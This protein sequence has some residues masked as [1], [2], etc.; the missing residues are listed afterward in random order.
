MFLLWFHQEAK[1]LK[2]VSEMWSRTPRSKSLALNVEFYEQGR[3]IVFRFTNPPGFHGTH[4]FDVQEVGPG[5]VRLRHVVAVRQSGLARLAWPLIVRWLHDAL[6]EDLLDRAEACVTAQMV[7]SR[8][9]RC[10]FACCGIFSMD[11]KYISQS[12]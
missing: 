10:G 12:D 11:A 4:R 2:Q 3:A 1:G 7:Q 9:R 6:L 8:H 5:A